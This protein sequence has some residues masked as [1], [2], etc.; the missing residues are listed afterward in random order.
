MADSPK[1]EPKAAELPESHPL[2]QKERQLLAKQKH[3]AALDEREHGRQGHDLRAAKERVENDLDA[4]HAAMAK[5]S[6]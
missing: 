4:V 2:K 6:K 3:L 1:N 5:E